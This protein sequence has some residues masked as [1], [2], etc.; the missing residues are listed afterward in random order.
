MFRDRRTTSPTQRQP[1]IVSPPHAHPSNDTRPVP[2]WSATT[3]DA[4]T[5][6]QLDI[7]VRSYLYL[8]KHRSTHHTKTVSDKIPIHPPPQISDH[9]F[10][11]LTTTNLISIRDRA[12]QTSQ[13][14][15]HTLI[16]LAP[17]RAERMVRITRRIVHQAPNPALSTGPH[18]PLQRGLQ[19]PRPRQSQE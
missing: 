10:I 11:I 19:P 9:Q 17:P 14:H 13:L 6:P 16:L 5:G 2:K 3:Y 8:D 18:Q 4:D 1:L 12:A 7:K 15:S